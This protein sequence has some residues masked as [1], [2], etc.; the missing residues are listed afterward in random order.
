MNRGNRTR[1][2]SIAFARSVALAILLA[3]SVYSVSQDMRQTAN[4]NAGKEEQEIKQ[5]I[6][7]YAKAANEADPTLALHIWCDSSEDSL[8]NPVGRWHGVEQIV[9]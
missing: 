5:S 4:A 2:C 3:V 9:G 7:L 8:I 6:S 1:S